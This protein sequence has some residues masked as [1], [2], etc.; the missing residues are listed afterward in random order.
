[1]Q[2]KRNMQEITESVSAQDIV[3]VSDSLIQRLFFCWVTCVPGDDSTA[4]A[5]QQATSK[6][7]LHTLD[8]M[9]MLLAQLPCSHTGMILVGFRKNIIAV[10]GSCTQ[11]RQILAKL[12]DK[13][14]ISEAHYLSMVHTLRAFYELI[15]I[16][17]S[18]AGSDRRR[19]LIFNKVRVFAHDKLLAIFPV[20]PDTPFA[21]KLPH[22]LA[23]KLNQRIAQLLLKLDP[24]LCVAHA[25]KGARQEAG[26]GRQ[27]HALEQMRTGSSQGSQ[28]AV[29][30]LI[31]CVGLLQ[32]QPQIPQMS[33]AAY[34]GFFAMQQGLNG[35]S[36]PL[37]VQRLLDYAMLTMGSAVGGSKMEQ[38]VT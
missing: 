5:E 23:I 13:I 11:H 37:S 9:S 28:A 33:D 22:A 18:S 19:E 14:P 16:R 20:V 7:L 8:C 30:N 10:W 26:S 31:Q 27:R 15:T 36:M 38:G 21:A 1:M 29:S 3:N 32:E 12:S 25:G 17:L 34:R 4:P 2:G 6:C 24:W 35:E